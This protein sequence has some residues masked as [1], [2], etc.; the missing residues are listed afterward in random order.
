MVKVGENILGI[1]PYKPGKPV[2]EVERELGLASAIKLAS[3]EN[4]TGVSE[5]VKKALAAAVSELNYYPDGNAFYLK[6][7]IIDYHAT[8][9]EEIC[10][11]EIFVGNGSNEVI[12]VAIRTLAQKDD[13]VVL[14][15][16]GFIAYEL[17]LKAANVKMNL[18]PQT[19]EM[20]TDIDGIIAAVNDKTKMVCLVNPN[21]PTG[22]YYTKSDFEKLLSAVPRELVLIVDEAYFDFAD[23]E[24]YPNS[25]NYRKIHPNMLICR[26]LSKAFGLSGIRLGY[27]IG[28]REIVDYMNRV[29]EPF[30]TNSLAQVAGIAALQDREY[31]KNAVAVNKQGK[32]YLYKEFERLGLE[33][34]PTQGN[35]ILIK[36]GED[37][38]SGMDCYNYLLRKGVIVRPANN[39]DL[40]N[41][42]R[43]S[44]GLQSQ[45]EF[46]IKQLESYLQTRKH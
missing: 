10:F 21:N 26:T 28:T 35:F 16:Q 22:A 15:K 46:F 33:Y 41:R 37:E 9:G 24:D 7:A 29:R 32:E 1:K 44:I 42:L 20:K 36:I 45:N 4:P 2:S 13:E 19:R 43:I 3:N 40:P 39:Y 6:R 12:D 5:Q 17:I 27:A 34:L 8:L 23:A 38:K 25:F 31:L 11:E 18:V 14:S 30:N